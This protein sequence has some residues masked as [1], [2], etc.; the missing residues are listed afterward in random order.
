MAITTMKLT[1]KMGASFRTD[2]SCSREM[3][4][5]QSK[6]GGGTDLGAKRHDC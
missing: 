4:I 1:A 3:I 5:E 2:I 6:A